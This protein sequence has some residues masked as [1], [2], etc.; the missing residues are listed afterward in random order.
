M[1]DTVGRLKLIFQSAQRVGCAPTHIAPMRVVEAL[2]PLDLGGGE[3]LRV[4]N[5][6]AQLVHRLDLG[7]GAQERGVG[8]GVGRLCEPH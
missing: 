5:L 2:G 3:L 1:Q 4:L 8:I 6:G 7:A